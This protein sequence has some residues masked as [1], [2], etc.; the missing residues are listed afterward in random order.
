MTFKCKNC[1]EKIS[2][3]KMV[4]IVIGQVASATL[5]AKGIRTSSDIKMGIMD[6]SVGA[7]ILSGMRVSCPKCRMAN[8]D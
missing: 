5:A 8:W 1:K 4:G 7:G 3:S 2:V 6:G